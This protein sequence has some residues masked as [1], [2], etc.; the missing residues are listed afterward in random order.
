MD[1]HDL[2]HKLFAIWR[3]CVTTVSG[4]MTRVGAVDMYV[5]INNELVR[6]VD[7]ENKDG[8][9]ILIKETK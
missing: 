4:A 5:E 7:I 2:I 3:D 1:A 8:K 6:I 9:I